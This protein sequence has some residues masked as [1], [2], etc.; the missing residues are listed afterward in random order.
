[1]KPGP[2]VAVLLATASATGSAAPATPASLAAPATRRLDSFRIADQFGKTNHVQ[3]PTSRPVLLLLGDRR[4]SE[5]VDAWI[6]VLREHWGKSAEIL[7]IADVSS[8]PRF[9]RSRVTEAIRKA[10]SQSVLLDYDGVISDHLKPVSKVAN[11]F[12]LDRTGQLR[13]HLSGEFDTAKQSR[14]AEFIG[15]LTPP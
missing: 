9:L 14:I 1:M 11:L 2:L 8:V 5:Q 6:P 3:F 13:L 4:G 12:L 15:T 10:R 7:G